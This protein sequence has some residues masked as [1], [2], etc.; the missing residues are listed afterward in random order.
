MVAP[1]LACTVDICSSK[2]AAILTDATPNAAAA[3]PAAVRPLVMS[4]LL[5]PVFSMPDATL[6]AVLPARVMDASYE[7]VSAINR[8][9]MFWFA[10]ICPP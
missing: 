7:A 5:R 4:A 3:N 1:E 10:A 6:R 9:T 8:M 2:S